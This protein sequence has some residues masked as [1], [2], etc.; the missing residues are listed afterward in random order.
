MSNPFTVYDLDED[1]TGC[2]RLHVNT[3]VKWPYDSTTDTGG[4]LLGRVASLI[5]NLD[6]SGA[7]DDLLEKEGQE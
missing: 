4:N 7:L 1:D 2:I 6:D 3:N 5:D